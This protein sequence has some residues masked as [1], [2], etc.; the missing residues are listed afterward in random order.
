MGHTGRFPWR[1]YQETCLGALGWP[2]SEF[3]RATV[4]D[5]MR[6]CEGKA[7][8]SGAKKRFDPRHYPTREER[9]ELHRRIRERDRG[10]AG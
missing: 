4:W 1:Q 6:A 7:V 10:H 3:W 8:A 9:D 5:V 2:P